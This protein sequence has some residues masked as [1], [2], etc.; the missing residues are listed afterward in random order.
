MLI[1]TILE[2]Y[3]FSKVL[4]C[5]LI[6]IS[7]TQT[8]DSVLVTSCKNI[9]RFPKNLYLTFSAWVEFGL[10][11]HV[12]KFFSWYLKKSNVK[13]KLNSLAKLMFSFPL[14]S[15]SKTWIFRSLCVILQV[16]LIQ[17]YL[18]YSK[19]QCLNENFSLLI[20][21]CTKFWIS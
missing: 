17:K 16:L 5:A 9:L 3:A 12:L 1:W 7:P 10:Y 2:L 15:C 11:V 20:D 18:A 4:N 21:K 19:L 8:R 6:S 14:L 13:P